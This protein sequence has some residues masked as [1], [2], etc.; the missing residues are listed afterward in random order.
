V[1]SLTG[2]QI[3]I[4][5]TRDKSNLHGR[6]AEHLGV[7]ILSGKIVPG[8]VLPTESGLGAS[9]HVSRT[10]VREAIK[11]L[12]SKGLVEVR[13][14][15]GTRVRPK[16]NWNALDPDVLAWQFSGRGVPA[17]IMD[18]LELREVIEPMCARMAAERA[19]MDD[20]AAI[21]KAL[22]E[23]E[24]SVGKTAASFEADLL[25]HM[26]ILEST[27]NWFMRPFGAL[28][29]AALRAS[30]RQTDED[31][32]TYQQSLLKHQVVLSAIRSKNPGAAEDAMHAV[33]RGARHD[34]QQALDGEAQRKRSLTEEVRNMKIG[35]RK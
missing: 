27:H 24:K 5:K 34:I 22:L 30:F 23:M 10:A 16:K 7:S 20:V 1:S 32:G 28:I 8:E 17:A 11:V 13:R 33:L 21:E 9:F 15:T 14:K 4:D 2:K 3:R 26:A 29:Q 35:H 18:L 25:F 31:A 19:T 12:T 6:I